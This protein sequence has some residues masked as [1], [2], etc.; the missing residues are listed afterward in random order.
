M[1]RPRLVFFL[2]AV[3]SSCAGFK[4]IER[5]EYR[6]VFAADVT[7]RTSDAPQEIITREAYEAEV[8]DGVRRGWEPPVGF[9]APFLHE[10]P[11]IGLKVG[12][13]VELI[14]DESS[15]PE[16]LLEGSVVEAY[17]NR[18]VKRDAW[19]DGTD[20]T[21]REST[22]WLRGKKPGR[23]TLRYTRG[24]ESKDVPITVTAP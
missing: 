9:T 17:W 21:V 20:V 12:D 16:L 24:N 15:E 4:P 19:K 11:A 7:K 8:A 10:T 2:T 1:H 18:T 3:V 22:L 5:G 13:I 6:R 14:V 23:G